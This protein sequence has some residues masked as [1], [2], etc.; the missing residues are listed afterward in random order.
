MAAGRDGAGAASG[1]WPTPGWSARPGEAAGRRDGRRRLRRAGPV[2]PAPG[3]AGAVI[4]LAVSGLFTGYIATCGALIFSVIPDQHRGKADGPV[5]GGLSLSQG[6]TII[7]AGLAAQ[8]IR[9]ELV[10]ACSGVIGTA[11]VA[12]LAVTWHKIT[13]TE[14]TLTPR[15]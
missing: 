5:G 3:L 12:W 14:E 4:I 9:P 11:L 2:L 7:A 6:I 1:R 10:V 13:Q 8:W 15:R